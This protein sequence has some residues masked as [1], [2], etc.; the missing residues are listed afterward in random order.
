MLKRFLLLAFA[1]VPFGSALAGERAAC[2]QYS[3][4]FY[5][6]GALY[7][8]E[9]DG[10]WSGIDKDVLDEI[11]RRSGCQFQ[12]TLES[13]VRIWSRL[14]NGTLDVSVSGIPTPEREKFAIFLPYLGAHNYLLV[15]RSL[16]EKA[17]TAA[18]F[19]AD[20]EL[21]VAVVKSFKH[22]AVYDAWLDQLRSQGRVYEAPD[23]S[24]VLNLFKI[25]RVHAMLA[26]PTTVALDL[27][28]EGDRLKLL[29]FV[30]KN[31]VIG[32]LILNRQNVPP[33][34]VELMRKAIRDMR[35]D[36]TLKAI[37]ARYVGPA[38]AAELILY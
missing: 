14:E 21:K 32:A 22:G 23:L 6:H 30:K 15:R 20:P 31:D 34:A 16:P 33:R 35:D 18:G 7:H 27:Q 24:A 25:G 19:L 3:A 37:Y 11:S 5:E 9:A 12:T 2:G 4:A 26:L 13:R 36:G 38:L 29:D 10:K 28:Q 17:Q 8:R 1:I